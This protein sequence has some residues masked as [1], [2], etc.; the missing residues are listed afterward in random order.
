VIVRRAFGVAGAGIMDHTRFRYRVAWPSG[1]WGSLPPE[2][3]IEAAFKAQI[4][5]APDPQAMRREIGERLERLR[6]PFRSAERF[7]VEEMI[8][9]AQTRRWLCEFA[10]LVADRPHVP[11]RYHYRP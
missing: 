3:G 9:P 7:F 5:A 8:E 1:D 4:Q 10:G 6:S 2:G 11:A